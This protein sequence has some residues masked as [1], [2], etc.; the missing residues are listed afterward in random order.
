MLCPE[1]ARPAPVVDGVLSVHHA[2]KGVWCPM[3]GQ[4]AFMWDE[5]AVREAVSNR[6]GGVCEYC[7]KARATEMH[8]RVPR[9]VGG[10]WTPAN[11]VHLCHACHGWVSDSA[12]TSLSTA[13]RHGLYLRSREDPARIPLTRQAGQMVLL[14]DDVSPPPRRNHHTRG[15]SLS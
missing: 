8:H 6:S 7:C 12:D 5:K 15:R 2:D 13:R 1:C 10:G 4:P 3:S 11:I 9:S 14:S